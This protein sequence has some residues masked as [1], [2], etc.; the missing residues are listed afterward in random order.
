MQRIY[1]PWQPDDPPE[2]DDLYHLRE[3]RARSYLTQA[4]LA[5]LAGVG[6]LTVHLIETGKT[7]RPHAKTARRIADALG[8]APDRIEEF[9]YRDGEQV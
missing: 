9:L 1:E 4:E 7:A 8:V 5:R 2:R 3:L 6:W